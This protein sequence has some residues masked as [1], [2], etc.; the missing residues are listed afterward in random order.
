MKD[1]KELIS[2]SVYQ[3]GQLDF[4]VSQMRLAALG[5]SSS[6]LPVG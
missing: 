2:A 5:K 3:F 4:S 1:E 6:Y